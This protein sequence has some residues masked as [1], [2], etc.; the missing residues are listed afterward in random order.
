MF[1]SVFKTQKFSHYTIPEFQFHVNG[2]N[3]GGWVK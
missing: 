1:F 3:F 2:Y